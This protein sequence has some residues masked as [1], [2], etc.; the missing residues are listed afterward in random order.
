MKDTRSAGP[1]D[2]A[3]FT[4]KERWTQGPK[5]RSV[6]PSQP[7]GLARQ[8]IVKDLR[9]EGPKNLTQFTAITYITQVR[10]RRLKMINPQDLAFSLSSVL[11]WVRY[12][13][14]RYRVQVQQEAENCETEGFMNFTTSVVT[15][16]MDVDGRSDGIHTQQTEGEDRRSEGFRLGV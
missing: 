11:T 14:H 2:L 8:L 3:H 1:K 6:H 4:A 12:L 10:T 9:T 5:V 16:M 13:V 15:W 7:E